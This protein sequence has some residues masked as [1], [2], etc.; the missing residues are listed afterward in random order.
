MD[1]NK[2]RIRIVKTGSIVNATMW[3]NPEKT[4]LRIRHAQL[5]AGGNVGD[6]LAFKAAPTGVAYD[7]DFEVVPPADA[8]FAALYA[9]C[10][11]SVA[12]NSRKRFG[13]I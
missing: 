10:N 6:I 11:V 7:Y 4:D 13:Y 5:R 3:Y 8:R 12:G 2:V 9:A 1:R